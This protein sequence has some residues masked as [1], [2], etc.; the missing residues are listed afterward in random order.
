MKYILVINAGSSSLKSQLFDYDSEKSIICI[1]YSSLNSE[2]SKRTLTYNDKKIKDTLNIKK[3]SEA[4]DDF[5][6]YILNNKIVDSLNDIKYVGHRVVHGGE[7]YN[8]TI[9]LNSDVLKT[10]EELSFLAPLHNPINLECIKLIINKLPNAKEFGVF[11]T[12]FH[13]TMPREIYLYGLPIEYYEK[14]KIRK[15]GFHGISHKYVSMLCAKILNKDY[16]SLKIITCHLG[17]G[18]S[19]TAI[20]DG[21]SYD[22]SMGFTPLEGLPMGTRSGSFDPEIILFL[23]EQGL[24]KEEIKTVINKKS[25]LLGISNLTN[26]HYNIETLSKQGNEIALLTNNILVN[27]I[28]KIIGSYIAEMQGLD[29]I[30][31]TGGIGENSP[32]LRKLVLEHFRFLGL[33]IDDEN[34]ESNKT[35]LTKENSKIISLLIPTN[36]ELQIVKEI[37]EIV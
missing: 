33:I 23:L 25:G 32:Y 22:T 9:E 27:R 16:D 31:F 18:Q 21:K 1:N 26:D 6:N 8:K 29:V 4:I 15:Y 14:Y 34:N 13:N 37:K 11:D 35:N 7:K 36:E 10:L 28:V 19:I 24:T 12:A 30:V 3:H 5:I 17:N 2:I 20:K